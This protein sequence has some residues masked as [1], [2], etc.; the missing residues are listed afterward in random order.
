MLGFV[1]LAVG[2]DMVLDM[3]LFAA[4]ELFELPN[5]GVRVSIK[6]SNILAV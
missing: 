2:L 6:T 4:I 5:T 3:G 1:G